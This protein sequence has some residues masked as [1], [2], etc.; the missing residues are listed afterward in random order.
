MYTI[1]DNLMISIQSN[2]RILYSWDKRWSGFYYPSSQKLLE[3][4]R[5]WLND[6]IS[7][8]DGLR[9]NMNMLTLAEQHL[10]SNRHKCQL[11]EEVYEVYDCVGDDPLQEMETVAITT[12]HFSAVVAG[13][14][15]S[16]VSWKPSSMLVCQCVS[17][18][19]SWTSYAQWSIADV[20]RTPN[21]IH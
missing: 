18:M 21:H 17:P 16:I 6:K 8:N 12:S 10:E 4:G 7:K 1:I 14:P 9:L 11:L 5:Y 15:L 19:W 2:Y 20:Q 3:C 13:G